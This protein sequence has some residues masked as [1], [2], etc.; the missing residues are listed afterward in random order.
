MRIIVTVEGDDSGSGHELRRW[1][2][3]EPEMRGRVR[4]ADAPPPGATGAVSDTLVA[5]VEPGGIAAVFAGALVAWLQSRRGTRTVTITRPDGTR[6]TVTA[7]QVKALDARRAADLAREL[8][9][10]VDAA[11]P[12]GDDPAGPDARPRARNADD[13]PRPDADDGR[14]P[15]S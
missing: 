2:T 8:A 5:L 12:P 14:P 6:I 7:A 9:A 1:L 10:A 13:T 11:A 4:P 15:A 3:A